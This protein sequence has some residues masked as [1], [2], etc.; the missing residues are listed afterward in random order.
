EWA[1]DGFFI[2]LGLMAAVTIK[3]TALGFAMTASLLV[4]WNWF[5]L[6]EIQSFAVW[7]A[8]AL[9][10]SASGV[11]F[12]TWLARGII[13]S[14]YLVYPATTGTLNVDWKV[15]ETTVVRESAIIREFARYYYDVDSVD[16]RVA[17]GQDH[18]F[19][20][21]WVRPW[22]SNAFVLAKGEVIIPAALT[23]IGLLFLA[24]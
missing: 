3:L 7:P 2:I 21:S 14:G 5:R 4:F 22:I 24:V 1:L 11:I 8:V 15:P 23:L 20:V 13:L 17:S 18:T 16:G 12:V 10:A 19:S 9:A 6:R